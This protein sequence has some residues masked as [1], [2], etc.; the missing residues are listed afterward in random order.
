MRA[1][2]QSLTLPPLWMGFIALLTAYMSAQLAWLPE[3]ALQPLIVVA[4]TLFV[5]SAVIALRFSRIRAATTTALL[6]LTFELI[7]TGPAPAWSGA[8]TDVARLFLGWSLPLWLLLAAI[9][10]W[11]SGGS[12]GAMGRIL[13]VGIGMGVGLRLFGVYGEALWLWAS[14]PLFLNLPNPPSGQ[15]SAILFMV[16]LLGLSIRL[17][18][19][20]STMDAGLLMAGAA[21]WLGLSSPQGTVVSAL[22]LI[23]GAAAMGLAIVETGYGLAYRDALTGLP[24]RRALNEELAALGGAYA[25]TMVDVDH[26]KAFNDRHGHDVGD[27]VLR[28]VARLLNETSGGGRAFRYGGEEFT[29]VFPGKSPEA[30]FEHVEATRQ[31]IEKARLT[32]RAANRP[33]KTRRRHTSKRR[34]KSSNPQVAVTA[35]FGL[36]AGHGRKESAGDVVK[37]ADKALYKAK[38]TGR[39]KTVVG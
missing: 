33:K 32:L 30:A 29:L 35:S 34:A 1:L 21:A 36:T 39:N 13:C 10:P 4:R 11:R 37:R 25:L 15:L 14:E 9:S 26:F 22:Y 28:L 31:A 8:S 27:Q 38:K 18:R 16:A 20:R 19:S 3:G 7:A 5:V 2:T 17:L 23:A 6:A 24:S 12:L